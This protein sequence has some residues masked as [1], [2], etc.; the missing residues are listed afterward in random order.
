[1]TYAARSQPR[2]LTSGATSSG[3]PPG[4]GMYCTNAASMWGGT[5]LIMSVSMRP[6]ATTLARTPC[7]AASRASAFVKAMTPPFDAE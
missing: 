3:R 4:S 5:R 2:K 7:P 6:G 1:M